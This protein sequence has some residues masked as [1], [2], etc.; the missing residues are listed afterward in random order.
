VSVKTQNKIADKSRLLRVIT[1][2]KMKTL[3][4]YVSRHH[5]NTEKIAHVMA[6]ELNAKLVK[7]NDADVRTVADYDLIGF[8]SGIYWFKHD[9]MLLDL[10]RS[11]PPLTNKRAF[12]FSTSGLNAVRVFNRRLRRELKGKGF[13]VIGEFS[14]E[15]FDTVGPLQLIGG[16]HK[17]RPNNEDLKAATG[18]AKELMDKV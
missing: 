12:I 17:G 5:G 11:L 15:G 8:G 4:I 16:L 14:C 2:D 13:N 1:S 10:V 7:V 18:F 6:N 9:K 3:I